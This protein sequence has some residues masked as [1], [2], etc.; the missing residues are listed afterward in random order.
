MN[1]RHTKGT[2]AWKF[3]LPSVVCLRGVY[4]ARKRT[5]LNAEFPV[6]AR[7][8]IHPGSDR[9]LTCIFAKIASRQSDT[10]NAVLFVHL[11]ASVAHTGAS[12]RTS[13]RVAAARR[14]Q[15]LPFSQLNHL[16]ER[17]EGSSANASLQATFS[18]VNLPSSDAHDDSRAVQPRFDS[19]RTQEALFNSTVSRPGPATRLFD[20][21]L[22]F[23][24]RMKLVASP[25]PCR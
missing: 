7:C 21:Y 24:R 19:Q 5:A 25:T 18:A 20:A 16:L 4:K 10:P 22:G 17:T 15:Q 23:M 9:I 1:V 8:S 12:N 6:V 13:S 14:H 11:C 2:D 3:A